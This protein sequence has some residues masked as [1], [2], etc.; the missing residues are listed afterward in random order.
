MKAADDIAMS[1]ISTP[2]LPVSATARAFGNPAWI[3]SW[4]Y[5][6]LALLIL[7]APVGRALLYDWGHNPNYSHGFL[8]PFAIAYFLWRKRQALRAAAGHPA[9]TGLLLMLF[10][11]GAY[12]VGLLAAEF[13]LQ[14]CAML[15]FFAGVVAFLWGWKCLRWTGFEF[16]LAFLAIPL[17]AILFN[18]LAFPLQL[19]ASALSAG[20]LRLIGIPV[21][22]QGNILELPRQT[23]NVAEACSGIRSLISLISLALMVAAL[24]PLRRW[25][26]ALLA[27]SAIP[28]AILTN[29]LRIAITGVLGRTLGVRYS[30]GFFHLFSGWLIFLLALCLLWL[31]ASWLARVRVFQPRQA[32]P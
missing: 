30:E 26:R 6:L 3:R 24:L 11:L 12:A 15:T 29:A 5:L 13:F 8:I 9:A 17:P 27:L 18:A 1:S 28:I 7:W 25:V 2:E 31:E 32:Q 20:I 10:A 22:Q 14:R 23:L 21:F 4:W 19:K 16:T